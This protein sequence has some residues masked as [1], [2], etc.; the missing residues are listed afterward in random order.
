MEPTE[1]EELVTR[2]VRKIWKRFVI[3]VT[4]LGL[5]L[6]AGLFRDWQL[7]RD[8]EH[9]ECVEDVQDRENDR[10][11]ILSLIEPFPQDADAIQTIRHQLDATHPS[12][13]AGD[14]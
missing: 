7:Q 1:V 3:A 4:I 9:D 13:D 10:M 8:R 11:L 5:G 2:V 6:T 14:C 12:L